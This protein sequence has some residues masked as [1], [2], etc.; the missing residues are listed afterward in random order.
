MSEKN[1][2]SGEDSIEDFR[3]VAQKPIVKGTSTQRRVEIEKVHFCLSMFLA[4][5]SICYRFA[6]REEGTNAKG[7]PKITFFVQRFFVDCQTVLL[8]YNVK[9]GY[10]SSALLLNFFLL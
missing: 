3:S 5:F 7:S 2:S 6:F 10:G 9:I 1:Y 8:T 4:K